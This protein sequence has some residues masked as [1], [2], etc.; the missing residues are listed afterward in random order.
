MSSFT[1]SQ[2]MSPEVKA[3]FQR[4]GDYKN[5][6]KAECIAA[7]EFIAKALEL[8]LRQGVVSGDILGGLF[9]PQDYTDGATIEYELDFLVPGTERDFYAYTIPN[10]GALPHRGVE[11][12]Y[13]KVPTYAIGNSI[14]THL[15]YLKKSR[16]N[17]QARMMEVLEA[18]VAKK[19]NDDGWHTILASAVDR[20]IRV[21]DA[22]AAVGQFTKRLIALCKTVMVRNGG[23]NTASR[24]GFNV[25]DV[26]MSHE[27]NEDIMNW[28]VDQ[29]DEIT[30]R[31]IFISENGGISRLFGVNLHQLR[32]LGVGQEYQLYYTTD[33]SGT[34]GASDE[35]IIV[36]LDQSKRTLVMPIED[37]L[38]VYVDDTVFR[39][40][41]MSLW[42]EQRHGFA[43]LDNRNVIVGTF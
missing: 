18:G 8:P 13:V 7:Q 30:R 22:D 39:R 32:E 25:T 28:N 16:T 2:A 20:N 29:V 35:E 26:Y 27:A 21:F 33:L 36:C 34:M 31:E 6:S 15:R 1:E 12:D 11:A 42:C 3:M 5:Y 24:T 41:E 23:G 9:D 43:S 4:A 19:L 38:Q 17:V 40:R 37:P 14:D 10:R